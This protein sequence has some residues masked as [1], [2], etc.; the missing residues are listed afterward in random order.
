MGE[1]TFDLVFVGGG[2]SHAIVLDRLRQQPISNLRL[3]L[4]SDVVQTPY[5]GMLPGHIAGFYR[6]DECHIDLPALAK[7][8]SATFI[9]DRA[10]ALDLT[11]KRLHC[12]S[13]KIISF[14]LLSL[15]IGASPAFAGVPGARE[16]AIPAKPVSQ[17]LQDWYRLVETVQAQP[18]TPLSLGIV[19]GG[20]GGV[21]L[22]FNVRSRLHRIFREAGCS[23]D[24]LTLHL[25]HRGSEVMLSHARVVRRQLHRELLEQGVCVH[26]NESVSEVTPEAVICESGL[27]VKC[28]RLFW[29]T[30]AAPQPWLQASGLKTDDRGFVLVSDTLQSLSHPDIFAAGDIATLEQHPR[31]KAGVFAVRQGEPLFENLR[32]R[33]NGDP[34][35]PYVPQDKYLALVGTGDGRAIAARGQWGVGPWRLCWWLKDWIDRRFMN[36]FPG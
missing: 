32:R 33:A 3:T 18:Q 7:A 15:D 23:T 6:F 27:T 16:Y 26:L 1:R 34:L 10:I 5:S 21:E 25:F 11:Q 12:A 2:H 31:P 29:V 35:Q 30:H 36:R 8:V 14:D 24:N 22:A 28:D 20:A 17:F 13:G 9:K 19:G 4:V